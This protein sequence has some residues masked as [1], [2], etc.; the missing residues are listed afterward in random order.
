MFR[1][2]RRWAKAAEI[3]KGVIRDSTAGHGP[4]SPAVL[5][6]RYNLAGTYEESDGW[7]VAEPFRREQLA[8]CRRRDPPGSDDIANQLGRLGA[9]LIHQHKWQEAEL[10]LN[11]CLTIREKRSSDHW[12]RFQAMSR[13]G[14]AILG[15]RRFAE[16]EPLIVP[17]YEALQAR[18]ATLSGND[19]YEVYWAAERVLRLYEG[20]GKPQVASDWRKKMD[21]EM[22]RVIDYR[23]DYYGLPIGPGRKI[24]D[25]VDAFVRPTASNIQALRAASALQGIG[26]GA[27]AFLFCAE[28]RR[29][30]PPRSA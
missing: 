5:L 4:D 24:P 14:G 20:W 29:G 9:N 27:V 13:L 6:A 25:G 12:T 15:Q 19:K 28:P 3:F 7:D 11:E 30:R 17:A 2:T 26:A 23:P 21:A 22:L 8:A 10:L 18:A 1:R 16:A